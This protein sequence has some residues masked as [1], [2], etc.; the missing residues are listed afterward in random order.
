MGTEQDTVSLAVTLGR[1]T[2]R[3]PVLTAS[4]TFGYARELAGVVDFA[5]LGAIIPKTITARPRMGNAPYRTVE[6]ASGLLNAIGLDN[7][8]LEHFLVHHWPYLRS[9]PT[10]V[11]VNIAGKDV[12]EFI[13]MAARL[14]G[15]EGLAA[16]ELNLSCPNVSGGLDFATDPHVTR[17]V[18]AGVRAVFSRP[19]L[20]KLT[21]AVTRIVPVAEAALA[22]GA[23]AVCIANTFPGLAVDWRRR[24]PMLAHGSGGLS[25]P[26]IKPLV[27]KLVWEVFQALRAPIVGVGGI[28]TI[29]DAMEYL[30]AGARAVQVGTAHFYDPLASVRIAE[31]LPQALSQLGAR[32][33]EE[34]V[35]TLALPGSGS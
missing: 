5:R 6:T 14:D 18:V 19:V 11:I 13:A 24:R 10:A 9:L 21:P 7:D 8:G 20:A 12:D 25:G 15:L 28:A 33:I 4:G 26:A 34:I 17:R 27:L 16:L 2:V 30:V 3:N 29:D 23:D 31:Q 32:R 22:A 1:L 35:G